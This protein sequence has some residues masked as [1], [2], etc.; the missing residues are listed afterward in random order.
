MARR[1]QYHR[2]RSRNQWSGM[3]WESRRGPRGVAK[4]HDPQ[5]RIRGS[6]AL[7]LPG[8]TA[9]A[10]KIAKS[11]ENR[12][13][14]DRGQDYDRRPAMVAQALVGGGQTLA[15]PT[16]GT[17]ASSL[18]LSSNC[19]N[20]PAAELSVTRRKFA[21]TNSL[22]KALTSRPGHPAFQQVY[23]DDISRKHDACLPRTIRPPSD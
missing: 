22:N 11:T 10:G 23:W 1:Q 12:N 6:C 19:C 21:P 16:C 14:N 18:L 7:A 9:R 20:S 8:Q 3:V 15:N 2:G 17:A 5:E 13:L 4:T